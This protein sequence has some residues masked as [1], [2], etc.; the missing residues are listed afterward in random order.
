MVNAP[1]VPPYIDHPSTED[2]AAKD[3]KAPVIERTPFPVD[4]GLL[5]SRQ[6]F[7]QPNMR[8]HLPGLRIGD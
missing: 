7:I 5:E 2:A 6:L 4:I 1:F 3:A 8:I